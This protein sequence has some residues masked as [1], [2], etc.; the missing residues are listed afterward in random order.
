MDQNMNNELFGVNVET[1]REEGAS[2]EIGSGA[3]IGLCA[4]AALAAGAGLTF[5][6]EATHD[7]YAKIKEWWNK[8]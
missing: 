4:A 8:D 3:A 5:G 2:Q 1:A 6:T 7:G